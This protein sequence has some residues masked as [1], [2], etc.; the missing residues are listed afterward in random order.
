MQI[1][2]HQAA[3]HPDND[4]SYL[5]DAQAN[6]GTWSPI[7]NASCVYCGAPLHRLLDRDLQFIATACLQC[8]NAKRPD[9]FHWRQTDIPC[10]QC[11]AT[12]E[13]RYHGRHPKP[14][15]TRCSRFQSHDDILRPN[16]HQVAL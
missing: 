1:F 2:F 16:P 14:I 5:Y 3:D 10:P 9:R 11:P 4:P 6:G 12:L 8:W 15:A 7:S 13:V